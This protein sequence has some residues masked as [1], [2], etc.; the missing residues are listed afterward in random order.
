MSED[1]WQARA[2]QIATGL[3]LVDTQ[4]QVV[5]M[6]PALAECLT[7]GPRSVR[8][9]TLACVLREQAAPALANPYTVQQRHAL[10]I[11]TSEQEISADLT[12]QP[13]HST[14]L[15]P[16]CRRHCSTTPA[17]VRMPPRCWAWVAICLPA[18]AERRA[19]TAHS[20]RPR[21]QP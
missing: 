11:S 7:L 17:I 21:S 10:L 8:G 19:G 12:V 1:G 16:C 3:A 9:Q 6:N 2:E 5:W 13:F 4:L 14:R 18:N 20:P 15:L